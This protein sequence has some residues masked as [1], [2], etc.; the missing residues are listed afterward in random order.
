MSEL[1]R[2][3]ELEAASQLVHAVLPPTPQYSWPLLN[4][5]VGRE[6]WVKHENHTAVGAFKARGGLVYFDWLRKTHPEVRGVVAATRGN[7]GQSIAYA[8][9]RH[10]LRAVIVVP[11]GNSTEKNAAMRAL[12]AEL[13]E[14]G[15]DFQAALEHAQALAANEGLHYVPSFDARLVAG[16]ATYALEFFRGAPELSAVYVAI[17]MGSG[18]CGVAAARNALGLKTRIIGVASSG[19]PSAALSFAAGK[20]VSHAVTTRIADGMA[21]R[22]LGDDAVAHIVREAE[23]IVEVDDREV[24]GAMRALFADTHNV[25]EGAGAAALAALLKDRD[26]LPPGARAGIILSGGNVD[27]TVFARVLAET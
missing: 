9:R 1:P 4:A 7:H 14:E 22:Q 27:R 21:C 20:P 15:A 25:A 23:R 18:L 16:V 3:P 19:A 10:G 26:A 5:R 17:G 11:H 24:E 13:I 12:G 8:A 2:L 6:V